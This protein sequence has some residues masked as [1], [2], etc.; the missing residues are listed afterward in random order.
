MSLAMCTGTGSTL[1]L[2]HTPMVSQLPVL[3]PIALVIVKGIPALIPS[4]ADIPTDMGKVMVIV[5]VTVSHLVWGFLLRRV[6]IVQES[7]EWVG[8]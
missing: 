6:V 5:A 4:L 3:M 2:A 1:Q 8:A 7:K